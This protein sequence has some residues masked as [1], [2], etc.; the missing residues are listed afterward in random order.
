MTKR[1]PKKHVKAKDRPKSRATRAHR[2]QHTARSQEGRRRSRA[3]SQRVDASS[4][5]RRSAERSEAGRGEIRPSVAQLVF[6]EA[7]RGVSREAFDKRVREMRAS[8]ELHPTLPL[9]EAIAEREKRRRA[10][11]R[12]SLHEETLSKRCKPHMTMLPCP[13]C[14]GTFK[15]RSGEYKQNGP[16]RLQKRLGEMFHGSQVLVADSQARARLQAPR[17]VSRWEEGPTRP[18]RICGAPTGMLAFFGRIKRGIPFCSRAQCRGTIDANGYRFAT[19]RY[20]PPPEREKRKKIVPAPMPV[21]DSPLPIRWGIVSSPHDCCGHG[22]NTR[23]MEYAVFRSGRGER[24][25]YYCRE[26]K[27]MRLAMIHGVAE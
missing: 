1:R 7:L 17:P 2:L 15:K 10:E 20:A 25:E 22:C 8:G 21:A 19:K 13:L 16:L 18:C 12:K 11:R 9:M 26:H 4:A 5:A 23:A 24:L 6:P 27:A 14:D 3:Q